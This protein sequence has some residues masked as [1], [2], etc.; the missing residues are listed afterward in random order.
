MPST[1]HYTHRSVKGMVHATVEIK[2]V[3]DDV[4]LS[5]TRLTLSTPGGLMVIELKGFTVPAVDRDW[6]EIFYAKIMTVD[7]PYPIYF[8]NKTTN[9]LTAMEHSIKRCAARNDPREVD[10]GIE[11]VKR[12]VRY[13]AYERSG[14]TA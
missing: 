3:D 13:F 11:L 5:G 6:V 12:E 2:T 8:H 4:E 7:A 9:T 1:A 10:R 14:V